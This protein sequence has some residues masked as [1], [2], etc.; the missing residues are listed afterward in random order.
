[1]T[2]DFKCE[3]EKCENFEV[4]VERNISYSELD[5]QVCEKCESPLKRIWN[6]SVG[7]RTS[8]GWKS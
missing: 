5:N 6:T 8:D 1:L 3:N 2:Y 7:I 4:Q